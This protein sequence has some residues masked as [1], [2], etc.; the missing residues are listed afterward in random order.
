MLASELVSDVIP[1]LKTSDTGAQALAW[2]EHFR[3]SHLPVVNHTEFLGLISENDISLLNNPEEPIGNHSLS[4]FSPYVYQDQHLIEVVELVTKLRLSIVPV[5]TRNNQYT[6]SVF[7]ADLLHAYAL[8]TGARQPGAMVTLIM[9]IHDYSLF[10]ISRIVEE[11]GAKIIGLFI[12]DSTE[13]MQIEVTLKF[14][15]HDLS[16][17]YRAF[18]RYGYQIKE[19]FRDVDRMDELYQS[20]YEE[21]M[22]YLNT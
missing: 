19:S 10:E 20:R 21:F 18:E 6:G 22:R 5:I 8:F 3:I 16:S 13:S 17:I 1:G 7:L 12:S 11:N 15:S 9:T 4:L 14:N 2:M